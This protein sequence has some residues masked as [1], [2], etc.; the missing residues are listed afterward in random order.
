[1]IR[2]RQLSKAERA[3]YASDCWDVELES[4]C[5]WVE[6]VSCADRSAY[7]L[8][9]HSAASGVKLVAA[10]KIKQPRLMNRLEINLNKSVLGKLYKK[11][12]PILISYI[13]SMN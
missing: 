4:S 7:D 12:L 1:M 2:F 10:K 9:H 11:D 3:H 5:G 6:C 8:E 13:D